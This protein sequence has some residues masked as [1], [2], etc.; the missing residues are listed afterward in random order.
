MTDFKT[1]HNLTK[2]L[3][4]DSI[5][6]VL[7]W[8]DRVTLHQARLGR[9][10]ENLLSERVRMLMAI[11]VSEDW[12]EPYTKYPEFDRENLYYGVGSNL[13]P[14]AEYKKKNYKLTELIL[15]L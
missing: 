13:K 10:P 3:A 12:I 1:E 9:F 15:E 4:L 6:N 7:T 11:V 2:T 8:Y 5:Y 14:I